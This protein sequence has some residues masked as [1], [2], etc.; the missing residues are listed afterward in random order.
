MHKVQQYAD[1]VFHF[2]QNQDSQ[3]VPGEID[4]L[5]SVS[6]SVTPTTAEKD[7][8]VTFFIISK[9]YF[10]LT[11]MSLFQNYSWVFF[12][13]LCLYLYFFIIK[14]LISDCEI[15]VYCHIRYEFCGYLALLLLHTQRHWHQARGSNGR[16]VAWTCSCPTVTSSEG[17]CIV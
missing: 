8:L 1:Y 9:N 6:R 12:Y 11:Y 17:M 7:I 3:G 14:T 10:M 16:F 5:L 2:R 15:T 13:F 4:G